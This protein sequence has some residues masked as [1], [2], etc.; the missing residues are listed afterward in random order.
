MFPKTLS[1]S[2]DSAHD[3][4]P[5]LFP[6]TTGLYVRVPRDQQW[7]LKSIAKPSLV[8]NNIIKFTATCHD[9]SIRHDM[10][11]ESP[12]PNLDVS[13]LG[14][15]TTGL[16]YDYQVEVKDLGEHWLNRARQ[17][18]AKKWGKRRGRKLWK[19]QLHYKRKYEGKI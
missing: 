18:V 4:H 12:I 14:T 3:N 8:K 6:S 13:H 9:A 1:I 7:I 19:R 15:E 2:N 10:V 11:C 17:L 5:R 16:F